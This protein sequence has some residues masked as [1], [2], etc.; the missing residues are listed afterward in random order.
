MKKFLALLLA[1]VMVFALAACGEPATD[2]SDAPSGGDDTQT[3]DAP[4][5]GDSTATGSVYYLNFKPEADAAW[6]ELAALYTEQTG[7]TVKV[8]TAASGEY[9]S[10][11]T[12]EMDK[13][14]MPTLFQ[15]GNQAGLDTWGDYCYDLTD[16]AVYKEMT[17]DDFNLFG[18]NGEVYCIGYCYEAFGIIVNT[19]LLAEAGYELSDITN[20]ESLKSIAEDITAR[21]A[22]GELA[23]AAFSSSGLDSSSSWR[24]SGHLAN[25]PLFY[26]FRDDG[27]TSQPATITGAYLDNFKMIWDLYVANSDT[28]PAQLTTATSDQSKAEFG[29][30]KAVFYQNGSWE[31]DSL[32]NDFGMDPA[33]LA[34]IPIYCGVEGEED[35]GLCCGTENCWAVNAKASEE[36]IQA[37]LDFMYWVVTS[38]EGTT[39]MAEQ[40]GP[41]PFKNAKESS[42]VFFNNANEY[43]ADGKYTVTWAFNYT[44]NVDTWRAAVVAALT[45]YTVG[46]GSWDDVV[47]AFVQGWA[48]QYANQ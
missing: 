38:E 35:A 2:P 30:G 42:N 40:F 1:L 24:F 44:P 25:M 21:H 36:D 4:E 12:A 33:N 41:I 22:T 31:Y 29:E 6:Q 28:A 5:G 19:A 18:E 7:V 11:L 39:M 14:D 10:T 17:T 45:Q 3:S 43:I 23:F 15:C 8:V 20:F 47:T 37:T 34:M 32:V 9:S 46:G 27:V 16:T 48:T 26:E 13:S